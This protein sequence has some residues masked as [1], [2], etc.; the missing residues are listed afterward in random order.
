MASGKAYVEGDGRG[1][2]GVEKIA[3][4]RSERACTLPRQGKG[5]YTWGIE[6]WGFAAI[7]GKK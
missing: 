1:K 3:L 2:G 7:M 6:G 4:A 5:I